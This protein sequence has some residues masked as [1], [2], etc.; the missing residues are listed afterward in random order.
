MMLHPP[1]TRAFPAALTIASIF[2]ALIML[3]RGAAPAPSTAVAPVLK[4]VAG[5]V[6]AA[7]K[8]PVRAVTKEHPVAVASRATETA[9]AATQSRSSHA[10]GHTGRTQRRVQSSPARR[11]P[12]LHAPVTAPAPAAPAPAPISRLETHDHGK[13]LGHLRKLEAPPAAPRQAPQNAHAS[14]GHGHAYGH[15]PD[16]PHGP[17]VVPPGH[18]QGGPGPSAHGAPGA[19]GGGKR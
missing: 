8:L 10:R 14:H 18:E 19:R 11:P 7:V 16:V 2:L 15:R 5:G 17:P 13:A 12:V 9:P 4:R 3:P 1:V 6:V